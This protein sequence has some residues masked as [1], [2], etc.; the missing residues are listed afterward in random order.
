MWWLLYINN[1]E[2]CLKYYVDKNPKQLPKKLENNK[3]DTIYS[4]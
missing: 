4:W 2:E 1:F 3:G